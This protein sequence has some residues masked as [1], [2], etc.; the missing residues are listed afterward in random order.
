[1]P[2]KPAILGRIGGGIWSWV[3]VTTF[4]DSLLI[5]FTAALTGASLYQFL[6][7]RGQLDV[8]RKDQRAWVAA[9]TGVPETPPSGTGKLLRIP[10]EIK[11]TGKTSAR[12]VK[13]E[14]IARIVKNGD[15]ARCEYGNQVP[16]T[17]R[18]TKV[19]LP[20]AP[21]TFYGVILSAPATEKTLAQPRV[22]SPDEIQQLIDGRE[23]FVVYGRVSYRD[24]FNQQ[25]WTHFCSW[26]GLGT[27]PAMFSSGSCFAYNE[28]DDD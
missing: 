6:I 17:S 27:K 8:M 2:N 19:F 4:A 26:G 25:H 15:D 16:G 5:L 22:V 7:L 10:V 21:R 13:V 1:M 23:F 28:I 11:N 3:K 12:D 14:V 18:G 24:I 20:N 9:V